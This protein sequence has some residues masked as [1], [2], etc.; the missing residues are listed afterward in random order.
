MNLSTGDFLAGAAPGLGYEIVRS[1]V[2]N[3]GF[4]NNFPDGKYSVIVF[5]MGGTNPLLPNSP[6]TYNLTN[7]TCFRNGT[8]YVKNVNSSK[9]LNV[10]NSGTASGTNVNQY[11][12]NG[13]ANQKWQAIGLGNGYHMLRPMHATGLALGVDNNYTS[14]SSN[15]SVRSASSGT[16][17]DYCQWKIVS[18]GNDA[19]KL[20]SKCSGTAEKAM[21]VEAS[22]LADG[23]NVKQYTYYATHNDEWMFEP[24]DYEVLNW[25]YVFDDLD[26]VE[27]SNGYGAPNVIGNIHPAI[28]IVSK[29]DSKPIDN[30]PIKCPAAGKIVEVSE[31][32]SAGNYVILE[33][34]D[35]DPS[36][37]NKIRVGFQHLSTISVGDNEL[38][39]KGTI[40]GYV[41][42]T[43]N[44]SSGYHL[45][46]YMMREDKT[47]TKE[48]KTINPQ[49]FYPNITFTRYPGGPYVLD[50]QP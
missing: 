8:F 45:H 33:T 29:N 5:A 17:P 19:Y 41:G 49:N 46:L 44:E 47:W 27:I 24:I 50:A 20:V 11:S 4:A 28:D 6:R 16:V 34:N 2:N 35:I 22:S 23:A 36:T 39:S 48:G 21:M 42:D 32:Y 14:N 38:V 3:D 18:V 10:H 7:S 43:G 9:Y 40:I 12:K 26:F 37:G 15:I 30:A 25:R 31:E 1:G 13:G